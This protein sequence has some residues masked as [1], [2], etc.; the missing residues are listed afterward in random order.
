MNDIDQRIARLALTK[1]QA[2][3]DD[4][5][6]A[7]PYV[8]G[9]ERDVLGENDHGTIFA[10][11][12]DSSDWWEPFDFRKPGHMDAWMETRRSG[13]LAFLELEAPDAGVTS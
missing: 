2:R 5:S 3:L 10:P 8:F 9:S 11:K 1:F 4:P 7:D 6:Q 13:R 12:A